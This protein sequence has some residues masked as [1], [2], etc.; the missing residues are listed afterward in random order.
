MAIAWLGPHQSC[1]HPLVW[2]VLKF[3]TPAAGPPRLGAVGL[4]PGAG[5]GLRHAFVFDW[6]RVSGGAGTYHL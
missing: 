1:L 3:G 5:F 6:L 2:P 4:H